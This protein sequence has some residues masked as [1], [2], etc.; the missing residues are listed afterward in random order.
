MPIQVLTASRHV[1]DQDQPS[2]ND[3][4]FMVTTKFPQFWVGSQNILL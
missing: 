2:L 4:I 1:L 3:V